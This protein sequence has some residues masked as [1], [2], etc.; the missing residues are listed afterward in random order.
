[1]LQ[2]EEN[3]PS[4]YELKKA[5]MINNICN[6][7]KIFFLSITLIFCVQITI[8]QNIGIGL[9]N[10]TRAKLE[11][12][13]VAGN[14]VAIFGGEGNGVSVQ[15]NNPAIGFNHYYNAADKYIANGY[16][17]AQ[18]FNAANGIMYFDFWNFGLANQNTTGL[19]RSMVIKP[20]GLVGIGNVDAHGYLQFPNDLFNRKI[21]LWESANNNHQY[22]GFGIESGTLR[23][24]V[25]APGAAHR[26][27]AANNSSSSTL[28][29]TIAGN[30]KVVI[31]SHAGNSKLGINAG[32]PTTSLEV[33]QADGTGMALIDPTSWYYWELRNVYNGP[34]GSNT[35]YLW[36]RYN[37]V[38]ASV[39][40]SDGAY[41]VGSDLR[42]KKNI[43]SMDDVL[44][45]LL[46]VQAKT[47]EMRYNNPANQKSIGFIAQE[48]QKYFPGLVSVV[49]GNKAGYKDI[50]ELH[51]IN[52]TGL[53]VIAIKAIQEQQQV[54][55]QQQKQI[56]EL[57][58]KMD[59]IL[60]NR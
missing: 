12:N 43:E 20:G 46:Q 22:Y 44:P 26:F 30:K 47:Y 42:I 48:F 18:W 50:S 32:D 29:M 19:T 10:P 38:G 56:D 13:G 53:S 33:V 55:Q 15:R 27:Y 52:Y 3:N 4:I 8:A 24:A 36:F 14:T 59:L 37:G 45:K 41:V 1:M 16:A 49:D 58:K 11:V 34:L 21:V 35:S 57:N 17:A 54:I 31:G 5:I 25:D 40:R 28:L 9:T 7:K 23:Y 2:K 6:K 39:I 51:I 60:N